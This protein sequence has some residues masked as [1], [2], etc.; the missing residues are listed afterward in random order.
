MNLLERTV[1]S[2]TAFSMAWDRAEI[3][4]DRAD[5]SASTLTLERAYADVNQVVVILT[6]TGLD[7]LEA[8][9]SSGGYVTDHLIVGNASLRDPSGRTPVVGGGTDVVEPGLAASVR[10]FQFDPPA[11]RAGTYSLHVT[12]L[13]FGGDGPDC[14]DPC[15]GE[16][17]PGDWRFDFALPAP[18]GT[19]VETR[20]TDTVGT[21]RL[22]LIWMR[23]SPTM[24]TAR[25]AMFVDDRP[26]AWWAFIP[27]SDDVPARR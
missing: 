11:A 2:N 6:V 17:I 23:I 21:A 14:V 18:I 10:T 8:P 27:R 22:E 9:R 3:L 4:G 15:T 25:I 16:P 24:I 26:V 1:G 19:E 7:G 13:R 12:D 5:E 20:A